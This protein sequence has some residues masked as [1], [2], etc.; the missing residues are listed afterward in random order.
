M[1]TFGG[2]H[3]A[4]E[5]PLAHD[6]GSFDADGIAN[7]ARLTAAAASLA[8]TVR[9]SLGKLRVE[10]VDGRFVIG[11]PLGAALTEAGFSTTPQGLRLRG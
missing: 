2:D 7:D 10:K 11:T 5:T 6:A 4:G 8:A 9:R 3:P 1:L